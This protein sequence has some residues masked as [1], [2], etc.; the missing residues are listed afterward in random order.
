MSPF[1]AFIQPTLLRVR[2]APTLQQLS[3]GVP[4]RY[5]PS[6]RVNTYRHV[7]PKRGF[8]LFVLVLL[9]G[10]LT[11]RRLVDSRL[12]CPPLQVGRASFALG[13]ERGDVLADEARLFGM[14]DRVEDGNARRP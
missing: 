8:L 9:E 7:A 13:Q 4:I 3:F 5:M 11:G 12:L 10:I 2:H 14:R 1:D 6:E